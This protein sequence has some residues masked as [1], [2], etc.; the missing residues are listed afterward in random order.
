MSAFEFSCLIIKSPFL[1]P[2]S[3]PICIPALISYLRLPQLGSICIT[4]LISYLRLPQSGS[5]CITALISYRRLPQL[6]SICITPLISCCYRLPQSGPI[7]ITV[8]LA[9]VTSFF[10]IVVSLS[11]APVASL[12]SFLIIVYLS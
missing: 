2:Q 3:G 9:L 11:Q 10:L 6:G 7:G 1:T 5:I 12:P 8:L 4:A